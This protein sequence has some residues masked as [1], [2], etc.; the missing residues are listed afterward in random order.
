MALH[1]LVLAGGSGTRLWPLSRSALPK[2]LLPLG[3]QGSTLLRSTVERVLPLTPF[4]HVVTAL[5]QRDAC[6]EAIDG[7]GLPPELMISEPMARGTGPALGL[8]VGLIARDDPGAVV[9]SVHADHHVGDPDAY[10]VALFAAAGW[11]ETTHGLVTIGLTPTYAATGLGYVALGPRRPKEG[12]HAVD[13]GGDVDAAMSGARELVAYESKG[14]VEKPPLH[15]AES[16]L[17]SGRHLWNSGLFAWPAA[18][19]ERELEA[20]APDLLRSLHTVVDARLRGDETTATDEYSKLSKV[21]IDPLIFET[22]KQLT[23]VKATFPWSDLGNWSDLFAA[24][25]ES[26]MGDPLGN[27]IEGDGVAVDSQGCLVRAHGGRFVAV[28]GARDLVVVDTGDAVLVMPANQAQV[29]K[30]V[31]EALKEKGRGELL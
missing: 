15:A 23:V 24:D 30:T 3:P 8:A 17:T 13:T 20:A 18:L 25:R 2:H 22:T 1:V 26:G 29:V 10:R 12:W 5:D 9:C 31:V 28:V 11:A 16:Y 4:V 7:L 14:F 6:I 21:A 19:F 27:V